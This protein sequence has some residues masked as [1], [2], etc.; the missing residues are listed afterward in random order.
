MRPVSKT[1]TPRSK[2]LIL[3]AFEQANANI[4]PRAQGQNPGPGHG[5]P[6]PRL[7]SPS[8]E[9]GLPCDWLFSVATEP[10]LIADS[11]TGH[12][13][14]ANPAAAL[15]LRISQAGLIGAPLMDAFA[16]ASKPAIKGAVELAR[17]SGNANTAVVRAA[18]DGDELTAR[19]SFFHA[20][21]EKYMLVRLA[22]KAVDPPFG[23]AQSPV[24]D[25]IEGAPVGFLV[26]DTGLRIEYAN[27][28]FCD[29]AQSTS[30]T[31]MMGQSLARW[32]QFS[33]GDMAQ[34][35]RQML[36]RQATTAMTAQLRPDRDVSREVDVCAV[37]VPDGDLTCWG[38]TVRELPTLN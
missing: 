28:A 34:L 23:A 18:G 3:R 26:T 2:W 5:G 33:E 1:S 38:F 8:G 30:L 12:I 20:G 13:V 24:F 11:A 36:Q 14:Q 21:A 37:A 19:V 29:M 32:L 4:D 35:R 25:A 7:R 31:Q 15:L 17:T 10:V 9:T 16:A 6:L 22:S 27:Q